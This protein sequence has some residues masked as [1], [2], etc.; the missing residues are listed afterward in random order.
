[1]SWYRDSAGFR[2]YPTGL[3]DYKLD[4]PDEEP[5]APPPEECASCDGPVCR[6]CD[7][8]KE[9]DRELCSG[10]ACTCPAA[11]QRFDRGMSDEAFADAID[12]AV[13][14]MK[15]AEAGDVPPWGGT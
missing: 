4:P 8:C 14:E 11:V 15:V 12:G 13:D 5:D 7:G 9:P 6:D 3:P 10:A 2:H 1:M